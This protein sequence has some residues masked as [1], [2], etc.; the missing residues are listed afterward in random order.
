MKNFGKAS[1]RVNGSASLLSR[2][3]LRGILMDVQEKNIYLYSKFFNTICICLSLL[4]IVLT[5][6]LTIKLKISR[7]NYRKTIIGKDGLDI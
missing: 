3:L 2:L 7:R 5:I 4:S 6:K 1:V